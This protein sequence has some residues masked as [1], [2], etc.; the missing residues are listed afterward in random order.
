LAFDRELLACSASIHHFRHML[1]GSLFTIYTDH[2][3]LTHALHKA[4]DAWTPRQGRHLS[5]VAEFTAH[6]RHVPGVENRVADTMSCP[7]AAASEESPPISPSWE[8]RG[9][10]AN[11]KMSTSLGGLRQDLDSSW[12]EEEE[13]GLNS[14]AIA[15]IPMATGAAVDFAAMAAAQPTCADTRAALASTALKVDSR[16]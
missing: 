4:T 12:S 16:R 11:M 5:Y 6:I 3:P 15:S 1:E 14:L 9:D 10:K 2:L 13:A 8:G 7:P